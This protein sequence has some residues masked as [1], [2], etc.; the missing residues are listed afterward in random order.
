MNGKKI[1]FFVFICVLTIS[2]FNLGIIPVR[3]EVVKGDF[4]LQIYLPR[5][6]KISSEEIT[7]G[8][9]SILRGNQSTVSK[10]GAIGLGRFSMPGQEVVINK[11]TLL[12]RLASY[13]IAGSQVKMTGAQKVTVT[14]QQQLVSSDK[15][16]EAAENFLKNNLRDE[17]ICQFEPIRV[18]KDMIMSDDCKDVKLIP[19]LVKNSAKNQAKVRIEVMSNGK[20]QGSRE[21]TFRFKY[22][23]RK[24]IALIDIN[25]GTVISPEN[26]K[27]EKTV[28]NRPEPA[29]W[30]EP[31]GLIAKRTI[32]ADTELNLGMV[33]GRE[34][35]V[36]VKRGKTVVIRI[37][38]PQ[39]LITT[40]G[41]AMQDGKAGEFIK[42]R[43]VD[44]RRVIVAKVC[45]D[46]VV[47]P[48]F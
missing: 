5:E 44:S 23:C 10:A 41:Q 48:V 21:A 29:D 18:P 36:M 17:S 31:Y 33:G 39:F 12:S 4:L 11:S 24:A 43:N 1:V 40:V 2:M 47:E 42:V 46:G 22:Y 45:E 8:Q 9:I 38:R 34:C 27:I 28:S 16:L 3:A 15:F 20:K 25:K 35:E 32:A 7:L 14:Q 30:T 19:C 6:I 26:V 13:K 37:D